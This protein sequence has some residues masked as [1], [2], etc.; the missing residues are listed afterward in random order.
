MTRVEGVI[1][2][3]RVSAEEM[4]IEN[5]DEYLA[6]AAG[7]TATWQSFASFA[8]LRTTC[9]P[10][11][12]VCPCCAAEESHSPPRTEP[13]DHINYQYKRPRGHLSTSNASDFISRYPCVRKQ[14]L[15]SE[16]KR[17]RK[18]KARSGRSFLYF[19]LA[20]FPLAEAT[21]R[22]FPEQMQS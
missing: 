22:C 9:S 15:E 11:V 3:F 2:S 8:A 12:R 13:G 4:L 16:L 20:C 18:K 1:H 21:A 14:W 19:G 5:T 10:C 7:C 6:S 17:K